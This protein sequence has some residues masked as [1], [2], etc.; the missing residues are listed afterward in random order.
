LEKET[1]VDLTPSSCPLYIF[2]LE[3]V[4]IGCNPLR[5]CQVFPRQDTR[6]YSVV[7]EVLRRIT[8]SGTFKGLNML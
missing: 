3:G 6:K 8:L 4:N 5:L 7:W 1:R 2:A